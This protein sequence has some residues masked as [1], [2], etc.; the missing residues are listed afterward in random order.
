MKPI[1]ILDIETTRDAKHIHCV[2]L[3]NVDKPDQVISIINKEE[4]KGFLFQWK[5][6]CFVGHNIIDFDRRVLEKEWGINFG[7]IIF[8]DTL[9]LSRLSNPVREGGHSLANWGKITGVPKFE[10]D[11]F[12]TYTPKMLEYCIQDTLVTL[13]AYEILKGVWDVYPAAAQL[14]HDLQYALTRMKEAGFML[15]VPYVEELKLDM[16]AELWQITESLQQ[17]FPEKVEYIQLKTKVKIKRTPFNPGSRKQVAERLMELGWVPY[18][19]TPPSKTHPKG[20]PIVDE[21]TLEGVNIP[22]AQIIQRFFLLQKRISQLQQWLDYVEPDGRVRCS[23]LGI[24]AIT[25]RAAHMEPN[26][27]QVVNAGSVYGPEFRSCWVVPKGKVLVGV[28]L[29]SLEGRIMC[30]YSKDMEY[31]KAVCHG[32]SKD[33]TDIHTINMKGFGVDSRDVAK[34]CYYALMY[35][36]GAGK[37]ASIIKCSKEEAYKKIDAFYDSLPLLKA[38]KQKID[39]M[40]KKGWLPGLDGRRVEVRSAH[41]AL[42]TLFQSGGAIVSKVWLVEARKELDRQGFKHVEMV[43]WVHD[44][45]QLECNEGEQEDVVRIVKD[46][47][48]KAGELLELRVPIAAE[49]KFGYNWYETH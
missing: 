45:I 30:H 7:S 18:S 21:S 15:N 46:A 3:R 33:G 25:H 49:G 17:V 31:A 11:D 42:N 10:F 32:N 28:D 16:E 36:A 23:I 8:H 14:E 5:P 40:S 41:A 22:Q 24:G 47:A 4:M 37:I 48:V 26:L 19:F 43:V 2:V 34:T 38:L 12:D 29:S 13:R 9:I 27:G 39:R 6:L 1:W 20:Q 44:E 35:G